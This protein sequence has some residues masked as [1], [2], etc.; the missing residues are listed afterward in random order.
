MWGR[1]WRVGSCSTIWKLFQ[2]LV[3]ALNALHTNGA[4]DKQETRQQLNLLWGV[5][6]F[7]LDNFD[8]ADGEQRTQ[9][10]FGLLKARGLAAPGDLVVVVS[11]VRQGAGEGRQEAVRSVQ[12]RHVP[13]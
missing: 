1:G 10:A 2:L 4:A 7:R 6:P 12:V 9:R 11:D 3:L 8:G 5:S 13:A